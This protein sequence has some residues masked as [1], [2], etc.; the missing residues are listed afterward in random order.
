MS[1]LHEQIKEILL[2][3][4][5]KNNPIPDRCISEKIGLPMEDTQSRTRRMIWD[6]AEKYSL[7]VISCNKGYFI[8][9]TDEEMK[10]YNDN[11]DK[12]IN[13]MKE[14]QRIANENYR[15]WRK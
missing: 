4:R 10:D 2:S 6:T 12:R 7:P 5:E 11:Y 9:Q 13:G 3:H 8:V 15:K 14:T 1:N